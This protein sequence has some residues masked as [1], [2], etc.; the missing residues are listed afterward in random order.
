MMTKLCAMPTHIIDIGPFASHLGGEVIAEG[1][2]K[3]LIE[4]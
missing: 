2:Y 1:N 4:K 3:E